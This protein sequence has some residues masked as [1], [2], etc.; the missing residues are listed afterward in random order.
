MPINDW[1]G[2]NSEERFW[3]EITD[4]EDLG[5]DLHAPKRDQSGRETWSYELVRYVRDG[6]VVLHWWKQAGHQ[7]AI[8]GYSRAVG[9][10]ST[11]TITWQAHGTYGQGLGHSLTGPSWRIPLADYTELEDPIGLERL[12]ELEPSLRSVKDAMAL[13]TPG[14]LYFPFAFSDKRPLRTTQGYLVKMPVA[15]L[16]AIPE[17]AFV[18]FGDPF[19]NARSGSNDPGIAPV[20]R[21]TNQGRQLDVADRKVVERHAVDWSMEYLSSLG[22]EVEDVGHLGPFDIL[23]TDGEEEIRVEVKGSTGSVTTVELTE[24]EVR[25]TEGDW[26][27]VLIVIDE[28]KLTRG[29]GGQRSTSGGRPRVWWSWEP[30]SS[31]LSPIR[32]RY[33][34]PADGSLASG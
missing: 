13:Q 11:S 28:I 20:R 26:V 17:L 19:P 7:P 27:S 24:G 5:G 8:V 34:L 18:A 6:D 21:I 22:Y 33:V 10:V 9:S 16:F 29:V 14:A 30:E 1:W 32:Y 31:R 3:L 25:Q 12:R 23:A 4:R 15:V 2:T